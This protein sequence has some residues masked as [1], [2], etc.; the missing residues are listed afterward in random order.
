VAHFCYPPL[1]PVPTLKH[2][3]R[4]HR[5]AR[6]VGQVSFDRIGGSQFLAGAVHYLNIAFTAPHRALNG[7][8]AGPATKREAAGRNAGGFAIGV[9]T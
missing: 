6:P 4:Q 9:G 3:G 1:N 5:E 8:A 2:Q 7:L